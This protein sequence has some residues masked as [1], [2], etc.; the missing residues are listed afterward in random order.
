MTCIYRF[1]VS[2]TPQVTNLERR[3]LYNKITAN[4]HDRIGELLQS[5]P[6]LRTE[7]SFPGPN[8][9]LSLITVFRSLR[10]LDESRPRTHPPLL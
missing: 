7:Q 2:H 5:E 3:L 9:T 10:D 1:T 8:G 4:S 6:L